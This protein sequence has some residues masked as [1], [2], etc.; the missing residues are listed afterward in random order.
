MGSAASRS[1][2]KAGRLNWNGWFQR[3]PLGA[4]RGK[5]P[6]LAWRLLCVGLGRKEGAQQPQLKGTAAKEAPPPATPPRPRRPALDALPS[7]ARGTPKASPGHGAQQQDLDRVRETLA[8]EVREL[9]RARKLLREKGEVDQQELDKRQDL[10]NLIFFDHEDLELVRASLA[11]NAEQLAQARAK[12]Q[13]QHSTEQQEL[14]R[15]LERIEDKLLHCQDAVASAVGSLE[16]LAEPQERAAPRASKGE[17]KG[18]ARSARG[19]RN[20]LS[21]WDGGHQR[22]ESPGAEVARAAAVEAGAGVKARAAAVEARAAAVAT[23]AR[24]GGDRS[25]RRSRAGG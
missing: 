17:G 3:R 1:S 8:R 25:R 2:G 18:G 15:R 5:R 21:V 10:E 11:S 16:A 22:A 20:S 14:E 19:R 24:A 9:E 7:P 6:G 23:G 12:L 13:E 4:T